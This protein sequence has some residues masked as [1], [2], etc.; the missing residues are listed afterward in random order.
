MLSVVE[1]CSFQDDCWH[2][3]YKPDFQP[4]KIC[5]RNAKVTNTRTPKSL[6]NHTNPTENYFLHQ[7]TSTS[8]NDQKMTSQVKKFRITSQIV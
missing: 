6:G 8:Q 7:L 5:Y 2:E 3:Y 4:I 1:N